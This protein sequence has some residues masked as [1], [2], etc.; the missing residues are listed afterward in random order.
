ME[1]RVASTRETDDFYAH[2]MPVASRLG[3]RRSCS[4]GWCGADWAAHMDEEAA[5][6]REDRRLELRARLLAEEGVSSP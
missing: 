5:V 6:W 3:L 1:I 2:H 4:C